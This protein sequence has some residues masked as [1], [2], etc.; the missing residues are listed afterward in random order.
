[1]AGPIY[2]DT[3]GNLPIVK[4]D[5][6]SSGKNTALA[7][8]EYATIQLTERDMDLAAM[9]DPMFL[10][11][12]LNTGGYFSI[13]APRQAYVKVSAIAV[14]DTG[15]TI[16][17]ITYIWLED[18]DGT[19]KIGLIGDGWR[20]DS[21]SQSEIA[22]YQDLYGTPGVKYS[23]YIN[24]N[25][26]GKNPVGV[27][28]ADSAEIVLGDNDVTDGTLSLATVFGMYENPS[29]SVAD[30]MTAVAS[31]AFG[32]SS[33]VSTS[34]AVDTVDKSS[35]TDPYYIDGMAG[36]D[37]LKTGSGS[38]TIDGGAG[39]DIITGGAGKDFLSGGAGNDKIDGGANGSN[40]SYMGDNGDEVIYDGS[41]TG[42]TVVTAID[43]GS[44]TATGSANQSYFTVTDTN[45]ADGDDGTDI[46]F[47][48]EF[49]EFGGDYVLSFE[50]R[51]F[52]MKIFEGSLI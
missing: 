29:A 50:Q 5:I 13:S 30:V 10:K 26:S 38:D 22:L 1:M 44:G 12:I 2:V 31:M 19:D 6:I 33:T 51:Q 18:A 14:Q 39:N 35:E 36:N 8:Y 25:I 48:V 11:D 41:S 45:T 21:F 17:G 3:T 7:S 4:L 34:D 40:G 46:V 27:V 49:I 32:D 20:K 15:T 24:D 47:N 43:D 9:F 28:V 42:Y 23:V 52:S 16:D 37:V